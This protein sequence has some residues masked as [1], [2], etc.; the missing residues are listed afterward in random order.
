MTSRRI[1]PQARL[2]AQRQLSHWQDDPD[3][4]GL[5]GEA[6]LARLAE[7][8]RAAWRMLWA[9]V[10]DTLAKAKGKTLGQEKTQKPP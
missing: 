5:R 4:S 7:A 10:E 9:D 8:E 2:T 1:C 6:V 3:L